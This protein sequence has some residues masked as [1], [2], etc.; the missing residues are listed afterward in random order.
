MEAKGGSK[1]PKGWRGFRVEGFVLRL[2]GARIRL[3]PLLSDIHRWLSL[4]RP[5]PPCDTDSLCPCLQVGSFPNWDVWAEWNG[6]Y[7]DDMRRFLKG[8]PAMKGPLAT[9]LSGSADLY[10]N[11]QRRPYHSINFITAHDGFT[12]RDLVSYNFKHNDANGA[13]PSLPSPTGR[14]PGSSLPLPL[15]AA[16][17]GCPFL[18][19]QS[20]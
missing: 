17:A 15:Y 4:R 8:D 20:V 19:I 10:Q 18:F 2:E 12:L 9:R 11:H 13:S 7:R 16:L 14:R 5:T 3:L 1:V 6:K